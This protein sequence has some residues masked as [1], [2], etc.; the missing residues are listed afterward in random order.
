MIKKWAM[1]WLMGLLWL[2]LIARLGGFK[3]ADLGGAEQPVT[4]G[5]LTLERLASGAWQ[6][7]VT[8]WFAWEFPARSWLIRGYN[9]VVYWAFNKSTN[10]VLLGDDGQL[11][12]FNH[13][14]AYS[15]LDAEEPSYFKAQA[16][17]LDHLAAELRRSGVPL[18]V[19]VAPNKVRMMPEKLPIELRRAPRA[20]S[21]YERFMSMP[22]AVPVLDLMQVLLRQKNELK[23]P[24]FANT[25]I[26]WNQYGVY[27][28][29]P[30]IDSALANLLRRPSQGLRLTEGPWLEGVQLEDDYD[31]AKRLDVLSSP[32]IQRQWYPELRA[33]RPWGDDKP[34]VLL[35]A[36]SFAYTMIKTGALDAISNGWELW[37]Y[38]V[39]A[40]T[41]GTPK[42][43]L[44]PGEAAVRW[45]EFDAVVL[46]ATEYNLTDLPFGFR[47]K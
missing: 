2:P 36:D 18:L 19:V 10:Y 29:M 1:A 21:N 35:V 30:A 27:A 46:M 37:F 34:R 45:N 23:A 15:G 12:A 38:G 40:V 22:R 47:P 43:S 44:K 8:D 16:D 25:G 28:C 7:E 41:S 24:V 14:E 31:L 3:S 11:F 13:Y 32:E 4:V 39:S 9:Q 20:P 5:A 42:R 17:S 6:A 26:H 33:A